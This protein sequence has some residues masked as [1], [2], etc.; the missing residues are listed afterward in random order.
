MVESHEYSI[1][2]AVADGI[3]L[4]M[5]PLAHE[6]GLRW[7]VFISSTFWNSREIARSETRLKALLEDSWTFRQL[8]EERRIG[9]AQYALKPNL[10][11]RGWPLAAFPGF[12][13]MRITVLPSQSCGVLLVIMC[14][15]E[16]FDFRIPRKAAGSFYTM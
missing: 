6:A 14:G 10:K 1:Q 12:A 4:D 2:Q 11:K 8:C 13:D 16:D 5:T 3:L 15:E 7:P 9:S